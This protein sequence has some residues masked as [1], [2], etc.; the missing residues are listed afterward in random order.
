MHLMRRLLRY[1]PQGCAEAG[2]RATAESGRQ[3]ILTTQRLVL[4]PWEEGD[5]ES[6]YEYAKDP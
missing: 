4:R 2:I 5:A 1:L 6:L 3:M